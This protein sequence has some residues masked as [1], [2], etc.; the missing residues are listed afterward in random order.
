MFHGRLRFAKVSATIAATAA[1]L[2]AMAG[3]AQAS[4]STTDPLAHLSGSKILAEAAGNYN[5]APS[6]S[7][8]GTE[9]YAIGKSISFGV[10]LWSGHGCVAT[11]G[12][13]GDTTSIHL[14]EI[15]KT[16][17]VKFDDTYWKTYDKAHASTVIAYLQ[18]R[19]I[20]STTADK[21][22][23]SLTAQCTDPAKV[24]PSSYVVTKEA[25]TTL[26]GVRVVPLKASS[27]EVVYVTDSSKPEIV[28]DID[29]GDA[30]GEGTLNFAVNIKVTLTA[31]SPSQTVPASTINL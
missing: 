16:V 3:T 23:A 13:P 25:V 28:S 17:Y 26:H 9:F 31:P 11:I 19:Y 27:H 1:C 6:K 4:T 5:A 29:K 24:T 12:I 14:V 2:T 22:L 18:G 21:V 30:V 15:G 20:K 8:G 10:D 7:M